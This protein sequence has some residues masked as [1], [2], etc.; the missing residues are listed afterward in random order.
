MLTLSLLPLS[1]HACA[2]GAPR[3]PEPASTDAAA[4]VRLQAPE[5]DAAPEAHQAEAAPLPSAEPAA[6]GSFPPASFS[7]PHARSAQPGDGAWVEAAAAGT[8]GKGAV[9]QTLVHPHP[10]SRFVPV[11]IVA[12]DLDKVHVKLTAGTRDPPSET[13]AA[14]RRTGMVPAAE[15]ARLIAVFNG[16]F[17]AKHGK[18][19]MMVQGEV[20]LPP[21]DKLCTTAVL[22]QGGVRIGTWSSLQADEAQFESWR[23]SPPCLLEKGEVNPLARHGDGSRKYGMAIDGKMTIRRTAVGVDAAGRTLLFG[24]G[25]DVTPEL[26]AVAMKAA[27]AVDAAQLDINWSYTR[28]FFYEHPEAGPPVIGASLVPKLKYARG[29][30]VT[31]PSGRDFFCVARK[32]G[33]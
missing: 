26:L 10:V 7:P 33:K 5:Q 27:G 2:A 25:E 20:F 8:L 21:N 12:M 6:P 24:Y 1:V 16:G 23:Q 30:Y 9:V 11:A 28:F 18:H 17:Q 19:G 14:E 31:E 22:K 4:P 29:A 15:Q 3:T 13:I 32:P